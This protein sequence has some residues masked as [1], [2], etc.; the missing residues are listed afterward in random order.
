MDLYDAHIDEL[1]GLESVE[2]AFLPRQELQPRPY[3][4]LVLVEL[5]HPLLTRACRCRFR[6]R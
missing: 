6:A 3:P 1:H 5:C 4:L 2:H